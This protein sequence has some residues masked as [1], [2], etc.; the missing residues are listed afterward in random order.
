[1]GNLFELPNGREVPV[2]FVAA[3]VVRCRD[4]ILLVHNPKWGAFTLPMTKQRESADPKTGKVKAEPWP[5]AAA[6]A[7]GEWLGSLFYLDGKTKKTVLP[8]LPLASLKRITEM[9]GVLQSDR[10]GLLKA[11]NIRVYGIQFDVQP[12]L[13]HGSNSCWLT[14]DEILDERLGPISRT[15]RLIV[16]PLAR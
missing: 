7:A 10:D 2:V 1:M 8:G 15:A 5:N 16:K 14:A 11:Y 4:R 13:I 3:V 6:R 9:A 12:S